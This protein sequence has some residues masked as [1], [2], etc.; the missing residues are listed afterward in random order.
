MSGLTGSQFFQAGWV[1]WSLRLGPTYHKRARN[2][3]SPPKP[4]PVEYYLIR[5][6]GAEEGTR[7]PT[8]LRVHG[9]EPCASA[10]A[11]TSALKSARESPARQ[12]KP[13]T[14]I[15]S[16]LRMLSNGGDWQSESADFQITKGA[17]PAPTASRP[18]CWESGANFAE[19]PSAC[20]E[21]VQRRIGP[22][23]PRE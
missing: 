3:P 1:F 12:R 8:P 10:N 18:S 20:Y 22:R 5:L 9:P 23:G 13:C 7:T 16:G 21:G 15:L 17:S 11:A 6:F 4:I 2:S 14:L 19:Y